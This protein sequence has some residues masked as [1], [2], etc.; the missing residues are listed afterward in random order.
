MEVFVQNTKHRL[1][2]GFKNWGGGKDRVPLIL[3]FLDLAKI[4]TKI[5]S[6]PKNGVNG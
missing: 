4:K 5:H 3:Q 1:T 2:L 6:E